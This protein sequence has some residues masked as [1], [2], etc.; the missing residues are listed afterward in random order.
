LRA[1]SATYSIKRNKEY[2]QCKSKK[3]SGW[4]RARRA[5]YFKADACSPGSDIRQNNILRRLILHL[6]KFCGVSDPV[7][8][9]S[10]GYQTPGNNFKYVYF[11]EFETEFKNI[12]GCEFKDYMG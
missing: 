7:E 11:R 1:D 4:Q 3:D 6:T 2:E 10:A 12:L 8:Q 9:S 5:N